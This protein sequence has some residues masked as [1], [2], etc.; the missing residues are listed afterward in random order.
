MGPGSDQ[1]LTLYCSDERWHNLRSGK[2]KTA[3][4]CLYESQIE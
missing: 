4:A 2:I 3:N 1:S